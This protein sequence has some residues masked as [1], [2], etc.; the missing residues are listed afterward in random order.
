MLLVRVRIKSIT[1]ERLTYVQPLK[2]VGTVFLLVWGFFLGPGW[3]GVMV[4]FDVLS[5]SLTGMFNIC[6]TGDLRLSDLSKVTQPA[7]Y[8]G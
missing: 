3:E 5:F 6:K 2:F 8:Q 1:E 7:C 4:L